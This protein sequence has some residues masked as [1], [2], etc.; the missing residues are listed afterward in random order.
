MKI[1]VT[2]G[3]GYIG[4]RLIP[5]LLDKDIQVR[6]L[7]NFMYDQT[8]LLH[9]CHHKNIEVIKGDVRNKQVVLDALKNI[10]IIIPLACLTGAPACAKDPE[11]AQTT[12]LVSIKLLLELRD[13]KQKIIYPTTNSG[14]GI[15]STTEYCDETS[16]LNPVS[17]YGKLKNNAESLILEA[18]NSTTFRFATIFGTSNRMRT[19][20]MVN[21]FVYKAINDKEITLFESHFRR[22][23]LYIGDAVNVFLFAIENFHKMDGQTYNVGLRYLFNK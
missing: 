14:Y 5:Q 8:S 6:V 9:L 1:L 18:K 21:D 2:G 11:Y 7:D 3:A 12:N 16:A 15:G 19:D 13:P 23:F 22:N 20:L 17:L 4:S 10:D